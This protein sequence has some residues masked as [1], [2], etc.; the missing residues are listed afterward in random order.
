MNHI[1][2]KKLQELSDQNLASIK[3]L[4]AADKLIAEYDEFAKLHGLAVVVSVVPQTNIVEVWAQG[5]ATNIC[6]D[7]T[8]TGLRRADFEIHFVDELT[9]VNT[10]A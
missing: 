1:T 6:S 5:N 9:V 7:S 2:A 3:A 10:G 4:F 8:N